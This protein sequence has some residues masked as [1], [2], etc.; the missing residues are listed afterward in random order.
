[1]FKSGG[2]SAIQLFRF[3]QVRT[4]GQSHLINMKLEDEIGIHYLIPAIIRLGASPPTILDANGM[5]W[6]KDHQYLGM[7]SLRP[8]IFWRI[9]QVILALTS[10]ATHVRLLGTLCRGL[11]Q[12]SGRTVTRR[13]IAGE[14]STANID[15]AGIG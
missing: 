6:T 9:L 2:T 12:A 8:R 3:S 7:S 11:T 10:N 4:G 5:V 13:Y 14:S 15:V 1:M